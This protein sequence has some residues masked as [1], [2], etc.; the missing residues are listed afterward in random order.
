MEI[1]PDSWDEGL[2][3]VIAVHPWSAEALKGPTEA[4]RPEGADEFLWEE[5]MQAG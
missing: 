3:A 5:G 1:K 2:G 4:G